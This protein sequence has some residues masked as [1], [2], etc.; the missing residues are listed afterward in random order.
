MI[1]EDDKLGAVDEN[2]PEE[3]DFSMPSNTKNNISVHK[4]RL[5]KRTTTEENLYECIENSV[6]PSHNEI[7]GK[8]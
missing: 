2:S 8:I 4:R 1:S 6:T 3:L 5:F 7:N